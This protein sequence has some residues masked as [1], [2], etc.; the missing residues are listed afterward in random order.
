M[1]TTDTASDT[2]QAQ[3]QAAVTTPAC[4]LRLV[5]YLADRKGN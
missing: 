3:E 5:R 4:P 1:S 2:N